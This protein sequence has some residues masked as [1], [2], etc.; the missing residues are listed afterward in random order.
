MRRPSFAAG[1]VA[2][3]AIA[4]TA[5][6]GCVTQSAAEPSTSIPVVTVMDFASST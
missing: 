2:I 6:V 4:A 5:A 1:L 3:A